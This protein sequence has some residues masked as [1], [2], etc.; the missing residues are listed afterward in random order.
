[1]VSVASTSEWDGVACQRNPEFLLSGSLCCG[2]QSRFFQS[3]PSASSWPRLAGFATQVPEI[4][5]LL[6]QQ[7]ILCMLVLKNTQYPVLYG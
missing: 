4:L 2:D 6:M 3:E 1:M 7:N 5:L